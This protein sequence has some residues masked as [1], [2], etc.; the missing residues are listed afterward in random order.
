MKTSTAAGLALAIGAMALAGCVQSGA[1]KP[2]A[3]QTVSVPVQPA[4]SAV[5]AAAIPEQDG[6]PVVTADTKD[7]FDAVA[8]AVR[9]QMQPGGRFA[10][11]SKAGRQTV[12]TR[13]A[14]M[15]SLF[16]QFGSVAKMSPAAQKNLLADQNA[17]NAELARFDSNRRVCWKEAPMGTHFPK[18]VCRTLGEIQGQGDHARQFMDQTQQLQRQNQA[19]QAVNAASGH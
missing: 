15:Q 11:V 2:D 8:S 17:I 10:F 9:Q 7:N 4:P 6:K 3:V 14:D 13:L 18:T 12:E 16:D 1:T 19:A 5:P